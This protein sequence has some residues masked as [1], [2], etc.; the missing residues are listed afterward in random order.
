MIRIENL[1]KR[2]GDLVVLDGVD[3]EIESGQSVVII[4]RSGCGKS[5]L[6]KHVV[7][8]LSPDK[9]NVTVDGLS[10]FNFSRKEM[11]QYRQRVGV[12]FQFGALFE[13]L[14]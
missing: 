1:H 4:G 2:F 3:L 8:L 7:G 11:M 10:V 9:G 13:Q 6:L 14:I 5:V 12:L